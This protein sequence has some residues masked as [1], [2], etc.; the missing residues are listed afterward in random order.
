MVIPGNDA[1]MFD[2]PACILLN[3]KLLKDTEYQDSVWELIDPDIKTN[4]AKMGCS[5]Y[6]A[7][8]YNH[9]DSSRTY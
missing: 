9:R 3:E 4:I 2:S 8:L 1:D 6:D 5:L 7:M